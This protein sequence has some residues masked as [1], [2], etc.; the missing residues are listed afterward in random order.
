MVVISVNG[1][2]NIIEPKPIEAFGLSGK[3]VLSS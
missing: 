1:Y 2:Y 3:S